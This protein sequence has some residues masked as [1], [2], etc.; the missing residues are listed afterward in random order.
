MVYKGFW[1]NNTTFR[2]GAQTIE[3][4]APVRIQTWD[5]AT[6]KL[7]L[8]EDPNRRLEVQVDF[9]DAQA[10]QTLLRAI[11]VG[12]P[13][14]GR[15]FLAAIERVFGGVGLPPPHLDDVTEKYRKCYRF[16][17]A[18]VVRYAVVEVLADIRTGQPPVM[19]TVAGVVR[20]PIGY[21]FR[22]DGNPDCCDDK[23]VLRNEPAFSE[24]FLTDRELLRLRHRKPLAEILDKARDQDSTSMLNPPPPPPKPGPREP[25]MEE[26]ILDPDSPKIDIGP[27]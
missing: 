9:G 13:A 25:L 6:K 24:H 20:I 15:R 4:S 2:I 23:P 18:I 16:A 3:D 11:G 7:K 5:C 10:Q 14:D 12:G 22:I 17:I 8:Y 19:R 21:A 26:W 1:I 27:D